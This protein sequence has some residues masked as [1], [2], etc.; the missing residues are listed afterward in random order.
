MPHERYTW[1]KDGTFSNADQHTVEALRLVR[2]R[3]NVADECVHRGV[4]AGRSTQ[5]A[6][7]TE[8]G[9]HAPARRARHLVQGHGF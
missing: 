2:T 8:E 6:A 9:G 1:V 5:G 7:P 4:E 3:P